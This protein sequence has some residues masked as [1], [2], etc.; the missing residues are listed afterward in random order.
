M[1]AE[2]VETS[3]LFARTVALIQPEWLEELGKPLLKY[4]YFE[5]HWEKQRGQVVTFEQ[6]SLYGLVVNPSTRVNFSIIETSTDLTIFIQ[7][8]LVPMRFKIMIDYYQKIFKL[9]HEVAE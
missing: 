5:P 7:E 1:A 8:E 4:Q 2:L 3:K 6:S 9:Q